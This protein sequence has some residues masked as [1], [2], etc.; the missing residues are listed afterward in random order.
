[1]IFSDDIASG[2]VVRYKKLI[3]RSRYIWS[4][5]FLFQSW[6]RD[7]VCQLQ[8]SWKERN[9][10]RNAT[11]TLLRIVGSGLPPDVGGPR[12]FFQDYPVGP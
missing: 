1:M 10:G 9:A 6:I 3:W 11:W 5:K 8:H 12:H 2:E 7:F 4:L